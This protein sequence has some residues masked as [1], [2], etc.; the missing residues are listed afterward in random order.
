MTGLR[1]VSP[2]SVRETLAD[3]L[4]LLVGHGRKYS[5][6]QI[7]DATGD[8]VSTIKSYLQ[9]RQLPTADHLLRLIAVLGPGLGNGLFRLI[10]ME[11]RVVDTD[12]ASLLDVHADNAALCAAMA[13][14]LRDGRIDHMEAARLQPLLEALRDSIDGVLQQAAQAKVRRRRRVK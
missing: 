1:A 9:G 11:L 3:G 10:G 5:V 14:A 4:R 8:G 13:E 12:D 7:A 2:D 6:A